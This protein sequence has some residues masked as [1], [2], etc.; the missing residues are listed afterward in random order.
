MSGVKRLV[1]SGT[2]I[3]DGVIAIN[4]LKP[5]QRADFLV[6]ISQEIALA[7]GRFAGASDALKNFVLPLALVGSKASQRLINVACN[8]ADICWHEHSDLRGDI[9]ARRVLGYRSIV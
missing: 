9:A 4:E 8:L 7:T 1:V 5:E 6:A 2:S 3:R